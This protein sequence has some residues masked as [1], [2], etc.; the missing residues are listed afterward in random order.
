VR[1][2][3]SDPYFFSGPGRTIRLPATTSPEQVA[4]AVFKQNFSELGSVTKF[5]E[6]KN[7]QISYKGM[8]N[9]VPN[10][11]YT[12]V[13]V[14]TNIGRKVVLFQYRVDKRE[15]MGTGWE[16]RVYDQK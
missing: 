6:T 9:L 3:S 8:T 7:V 4:S 14:D 11:T 10:D 15:K 1:Q 16:Y 13:L 5:L 2:E 12:A